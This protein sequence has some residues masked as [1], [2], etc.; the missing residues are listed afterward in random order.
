MFNKLGCTREDGP[1][2]LLTDIHIQRVCCTLV[3]D[4]VIVNT[5]PDHLIPGSNPPFHNWSP[6]SPERYTA[7]ED[8]VVIIRVVF[9]FRCCIIADRMRRWNKEERYH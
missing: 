5:I 7:L 2:H 6:A 3:E 9:I 8:K 4:R 1:T